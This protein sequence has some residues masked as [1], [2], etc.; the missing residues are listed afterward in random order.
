MHS[1]SNTTVPGVLDDDP[2]TILLRKGE[3]LLNIA[4]ACCIDDI[5]WQGPKITALVPG[6][7]IAKYAGSVGVDRVTAFG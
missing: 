1:P 3:R 7:S 4:R 6:T 5:N 2:D